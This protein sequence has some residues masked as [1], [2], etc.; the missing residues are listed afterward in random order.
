MPAKTKAASDKAADARSGN[1]FNPAVFAEAVKRENRCYRPY[2]TFNLSPNIKKSML[3]C[4]RDRAT[5]S[6]NQFIHIDIVLL[7]KPTDAVPTDL[8]GNLD[9]E[10]FHREAR[11]N[12]PPREKYLAPLTQSQAYGWDV[13]PILSLK[14]PRF[15]HPKI[16]TEI[17]RTPRPV[18]Q[19]KADKKG[20]K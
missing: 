3:Q 1:A 10:Y 7:S 5:H 18:P 11:R 6:L 16:S 4:T 20:S 17:T 12:L 9:Q 19:A 14:D 13:K 15:H 8:E 2:E